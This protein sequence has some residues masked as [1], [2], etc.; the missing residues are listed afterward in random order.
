MIV[1]H[2]N[3]IEKVLIA[4]MIIVLGKGIVWR[5]NAFPEFELK[6]PIPS[7]N[8]WLISTQKTTISMLCLLIY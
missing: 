2:L 4:Q 3:A 8:L 1:S 5:I 7:S 6:K